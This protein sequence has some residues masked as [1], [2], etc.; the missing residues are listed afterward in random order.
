MCVCMYIH[1]DHAHAEVGSV[2]LYYKYV[3]SDGGSALY[4]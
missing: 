4:L 3:H 2:S 1:T